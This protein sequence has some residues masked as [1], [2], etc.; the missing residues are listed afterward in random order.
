MLLTKN[1]LKEGDVDEKNI[2]IIRIAEY[3]V[4][5]IALENYSLALI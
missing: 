3:H 5:A 1:E 4:Q 2:I